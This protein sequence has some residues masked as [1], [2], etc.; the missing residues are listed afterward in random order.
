[1]KQEINNLPQVCTAQ[2]TIQIENYGTI[3]K[4]QTVLIKPLDNKN[5]I[6]F[7][8]SGTFPVILSNENKIHF[9]RQVNI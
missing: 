2:N 1:M 8:V 4:G 5:F 7:L 9:K 6:V 3:A